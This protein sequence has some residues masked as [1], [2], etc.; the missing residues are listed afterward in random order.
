VL[1]LE[2]LQAHF[3]Q[4]LIVKGLAGRV[5]RLNI[6]TPED[7][8]VESARKGGPTGEETEGTENGM[9]GAERGWG[10]TFMGHDSR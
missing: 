7:G 8:N 9:D 4:L 5:E 3:L 6:G 10:A 2:W 1:I